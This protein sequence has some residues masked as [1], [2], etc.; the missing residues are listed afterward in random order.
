MSGLEPLNLRS[1]SD[2]FGNSTALIGRL[3]HHWKLL[4]GRYRP[5]ER[6]LN[7]QSV[8]QCCQPEAE[9]GSRGILRE[10]VRPR[11]RPRTK[12]YPEVKRTKIPRL[13]WESNSRWQKPLGKACFSHV[14]PLNLKRFPLSPPFRTS[15]TVGRCKRVCANRVLLLRL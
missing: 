2:A 4:K 10:K 14:L 12:R 11:T 1:K 9:S 6:Q 5:I 3:G 13:F 8:K 15:R 7:M